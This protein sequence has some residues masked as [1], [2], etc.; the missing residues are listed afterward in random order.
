MAT[1]TLFELEPRSARLASFQQLG[2]ARLVA[3]GKGKAGGLCHWCNIYGHSGSHGNA[4]EAD[5]TNSIVAA[6]FEDYQ[7]RGPGPA[8]LVGDVNAEPA[9]LPALQELLLNL[10]W[11]DLGAAAAMWGQ[12]ASVPTCLTKKSNEPTRR[13]YI[14]FSPAALALVRGLVV[15]PGDLC[16]THSTLEVHFDLDAP[17]YSRNKQRL[18][19]SLDSLVQDAFVHLFGEP[20][21]LLTKMIS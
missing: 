14:F 5:A 11:T 15:R 10:G 9:D 4:S 6:I 13:D 12:P 21:P 20:P 19:T 17:A 8:F 7:I 18:P 16:P 3:H 2:R 1:D